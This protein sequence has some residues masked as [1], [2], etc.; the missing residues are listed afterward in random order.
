MEDEIDDDAVAGFL[1]SPDGFAFELGLGSNVIGRSEEHCDIVLDSSKT[2]SSTRPHRYH[3]RPKT[4]SN[5]M[6]D[7]RLRFFKRLLH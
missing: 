5:K 7:N 3:V 6:H 1:V 2:V 4:K